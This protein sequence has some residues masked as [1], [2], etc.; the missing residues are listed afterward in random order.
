MRRPGAGAPGTGLLQREIHSLCATGH[1]NAHFAHGHG[2]GL[3]AAMYSVG[4]EVQV[5]SASNG[6]W[7]D[8]KVTAVHRDGS[9]D[10]KYHLS[11]QIKQVPRSQQT[12]T[13]RRPGA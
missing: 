10:V 7:M 1:D 5:L 12:T 6:Q 2:D 3:A 13:M 4:D 11:G 9:C 8:A